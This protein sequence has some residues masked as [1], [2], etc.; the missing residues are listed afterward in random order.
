VQQEGARV[1]APP[2]RSGRTGLGG[3]S[4]R[5]RRES[6]EDPMNAREGPRQGK[7]TQVVLGSA[8]HLERVQIPSRRRKDIRLGLEKL[9]FE[10][11]KVK[12]KR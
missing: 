6:G 1:A 3:W 11:G 2:L 5:F 10:K 7:R 8:G 9:A 4:N 12:E